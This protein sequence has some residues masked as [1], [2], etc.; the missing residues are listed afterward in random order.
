[1]NARLT[2]RRVG[3]LLLAAGLCVVVVV[4]VLRRPRPDPRAQE[5]VLHV[6]DR[7]SA[8]IEV[9][10][11]SDG[12]RVAWVQSDRQHNWA[13]VDGQGESAYDCVFGFIFSPDGQHYAYLAGDDLQQANLNSPVIMPG[14]WAPAV[15]GRWCVVF[16]GQPGPEFDGLRVEALGFSPDSKRLAYMARR[17]DQWFPVIDGQPGPGYDDI[18]VW[19]RPFYLWED[20]SYALC[21]SPD[22]ERVAYI[23]RTGDKCCAVIDGRAGPQFDEIRRVDFSPDS[24]RVAYAGRL[25]NRWSVVVDGQSGPAYDRA[26]CVTF[27]PDGKRFA[28]VA[29]IGSRSCIVLDG[30]VGPLYE[31]VQLFGFSPDSQRLG[32]AVKSGN[33]WFPVVDGRQEPAQEEVLWLFFS[34]DSRRVA[35]VAGETDNWRVMLDG[36]AGPSHSG[37]SLVQFSPNSKRL[38]YVARRVVRRFKRQGLRMW[39]DLVSKDFVV[40]DGRSG[41]KY[42]RILRLVF[43]PDSSHLVYVA[44]EEGR[45][46]VVVDGRAGPAYDSISCKPVFRE[47][48]S[49]EYVAQR[50]AML[51]RV[52]VAPD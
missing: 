6:L 50:G 4:S 9:C 14:L 42:D 30:K 8:N 25:G 10:P 22:S 34:P 48:G 23:A 21:F 32:Y 11:T 3:V 36:Q 12:F 13:V 19:G 28:Y 27:S 47:D 45:S 49:V 46:F 31:G 39:M 5:E 44:Q 29:E 1:M 43:S 52:T 18:Q 41:P 24:K 16:D 38:A 17:D 40:I 2:R 7:G 26:G 35:Y 15:R 20:L 37:V 51:Y 33:T